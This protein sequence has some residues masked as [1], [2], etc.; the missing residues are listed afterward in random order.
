MRHHV[1]ECFPD[2]NDPNSVVLVSFDETINGTITG[3][4]YVG[5]ATTAEGTLS[6]IASGT[7]E[8]K[9]VAD[10]CTVRV[11]EAPIPLEGFVAAGL[12]GTHILQTGR[13]VAID[14]NLIEI[15]GPQTREQTGRLELQP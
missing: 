11:I 9:D 15:V 13:L 10:T 2:P 3:G 1:V 8:S 7:G 14:F 12:K 6:L 4:R 5:S